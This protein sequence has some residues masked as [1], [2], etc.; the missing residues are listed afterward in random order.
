MYFVNV[1]VLQSRFNSTTSSD[2]K[3]TL[4][5]LKQV[6]NCTSFGK[7][8]KNNMK[9]AEDFLEVALCARVVTAAKQI[10]KTSNVSGDCEIVA[11]AIVDQFIKVSLPSFEESFSPPNDDDVDVCIDDGSVDHRPDDSVDHCYDDSVY[12]Y[13][14]D[15]SYIGIDLAWLS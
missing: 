4:F 5:H 15:F 14:T 7:I 12:T 2:D 10:M 8:P 9:A 11:K 1:Q 13:V 3:G 6:I